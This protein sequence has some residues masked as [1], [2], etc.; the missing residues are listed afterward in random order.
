MKKLIC[1]A[2]AIFMMLPIIASCNKKPTTDENLSKSDDIVLSEEY[3]IVRADL[4]DSQT[5][6][7]AAL[8]HS[9]I[10]EI[11]GVDIDLDTDY[12]KRGEEIPKRKEIL[13]GQTNRPTTFDRTTLAAG[14]YYVG[15][16]G[17]YIIIDASDPKT[18]HKAIKNV[19]SKWL[20]EG[21]GIGINKKGELI[22][23][24]D[25]CSQ[26]NGLYS[27]IDQQLQELDGNIKDLETLKKAKDL[28][29]EEYL[30]TLSSSEDGSD[31]STE[32]IAN[33]TTKITINNTTMKVMTKVVGN[34]PKDGYPLFLV[35]HGGGYDP[36]Q[37]TNEGQW[38]GMADRY[39]SIPG[40]YCSIRSVS[41]FE[42]SGQIF[43]TDISWPFYD[44]IIQNCIAYM[45]ANPNQ[46]YIVGYSAGGNGVYQIAPRITDR[47]A[48]ANMTAG[49]PEGISLINLYNMPFYLQVGELDT[50]YSRYTITVEY[51]QKLDDLAARFGGG[52]VHECFVHYDTVHG[53][54]GDNK[55]GQTVIADIFAWYNAKRGAGSYTG[56]TKVTETHAAKLMTQ[57]TRNPIPERVIWELSVT[58]KSNGHRGIDSFYWL[59]TTLQT[60][61]IDA[62]Y[63]KSTNTVTIKTDKV[64]KG[65]ITVYLSEDM[66]DIFSP[67]N[68]VLP[69]GT[70][71]TI[72]PEISVAT[73][74]ETTAERGD[75]NYQ[76]CAQFTF[77]NG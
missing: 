19:C 68:I 55:S 41:D 9:T 62:S 38:A 16:E 53:K 15:I 57:H 72:T 34:A 77:T 69:D 76:F 45:N 59:S 75:P 61:I 35:Y 74:R 20:G 67:V 25:I 5:I 17:D 73:L 29:W 56:G 21:D 43:S 71:K 3:R 63:D 44:R 64:G 7:A 24:A 1:I 13:I 46:V 31:R 22:M 58:A 26:V 51:A 49:H 27:Y 2:L 4:A 30:E 8:L 48:S 42:Q 54:V 39:A 52:Y 18:L 6:K 40:I 12:V 14:E 47:L 32:I 66:V 36:E 23:N 10:L 60:G 28:V 33:K 11:T 65:E 37:D 50:P 70:T